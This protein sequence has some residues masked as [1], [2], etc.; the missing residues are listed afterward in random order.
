MQW[1]AQFRKCAL[2]QSGKPSAAPFGTSQWRELP[3]PE[4]IILTSVH[5]RK[6]A[7]PYHCIRKE[8]L[9]D[10]CA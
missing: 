6:V 1:T 4:P 10:G 2:T 5:A 3:H 8:D 7:L 9:I